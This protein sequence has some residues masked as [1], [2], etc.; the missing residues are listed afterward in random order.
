MAACQTPVE[1]GLP[2]IFVFFCFFSFL[3]GFGLLSAGLFG[4][5]R[6]FWFSRWFLTSVTSEALMPSLYLGQGLRKRLAG[7]G[8]YDYLGPMKGPDT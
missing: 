5:F 8:I 2:R 7:Q 4:F 1:A 6:F 3:D